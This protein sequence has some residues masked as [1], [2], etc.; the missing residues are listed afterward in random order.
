MIWFS[1]VGMVGS[2]EGFSL[3]DI[4]AAISLLAIDFEVMVTGDAR[5]VDTHVQRY[6]YKNAIGDRLS[7]KSADWDGLGRSAGPVRNQEIVDGIMFLA[8]LWDLRSRGTRDTI[9]RAL[10][11]GVPVAIFPAGFRDELG[12]RW[13]KFSA[14]G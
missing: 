6:C 3:E 9:N 1:R 2:R 13:K 4:E 10:R 14:E 7:V 12:S 8:A 5:G 11:S